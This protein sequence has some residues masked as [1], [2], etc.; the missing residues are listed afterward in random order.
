MDDSDG[1]LQIKRG[2]PKK[3]CKNIKLN[4]I[5]FPINSIQ[6][7]GM[8]YSELKKIY[9]NKSYNQ[10]LRNMIMR[11]PIIVKLPSFILKCKLQNFLEE[12]AKQLMISELELVGFTIVLEKLKINHFDIPPEELLKLCFFISKNVFES[13]QEILI[14]IK[15]TL[16]LEY[17]NFEINFIR[18]SQG[19]SFTISEINKRYGEF[20]KSMHSDINYSY[21]VDNIIRSSPPYQMTGRNAVKNSDETHKKPLQIKQKQDIFKITTRSTKYKSITEEADDDQM[22]ALEYYNIMPLIENDLYLNPNETISNK[23]IKNSFE[24]FNDENP[25]FFYNEDAEI[26]LNLV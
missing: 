15:S 22:S 3:N 19:I 11:V 23:T 4:A 26:L 24:L 16:K 5:W 8:H 25:A 2:R 18:L 17:K 10:K 9:T 13:D 21:Y 1:L 20:E 6:S 7:I 14:F 12:S